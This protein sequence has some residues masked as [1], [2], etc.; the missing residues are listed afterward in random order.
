[1]RGQTDRASGTLFRR[2]AA[3]LGWLAVGHPADG[4]REPLDDDGPGHRRSCTLMLRCR[5]RE[6][7]LA[8]Q[9]AYPFDC[10]R[11]P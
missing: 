7:C 3:F 2:L 9:A 8:A 11:H 1:M 10:F 4:P 6:R 5:G